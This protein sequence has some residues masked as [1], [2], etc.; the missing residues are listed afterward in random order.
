[1]LL[2]GFSEGYQ[3]LA[4]D[5]D[6][7]GRLL[8][9]EEVGDAPTYKRAVGI[10]EFWLQQ[11]PKGLLGPGPGGDSDGLLGGLGELVGNGSDD[12]FSMPA[13]GDGGGDP[14]PATNRML[15]PAVLGGGFFVTL[16]LVSSLVLGFGGLGAFA[17][18]TVGTGVVAVVPLAHRLA[19]SVEFDD[20]EFDLSGVADAIG[21]G[22]SPQPAAD[23]GGE[24]SE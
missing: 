12:G 9:L 22:D 20:I 3:A 13:D 23:D 21:A 1:V 11:H 18:A 6:A 16:L 5:V 8:E 7:D 17:A 24:D 10:C 19:G 14:A 2:C 4:F 15:M